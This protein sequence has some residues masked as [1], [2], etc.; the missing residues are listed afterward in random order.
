MWVCEDPCYCAELGWLVG[1]QWHLPPNPDQGGDTNPPL[2][3]MPKAPG[4]C[5]PAAVVWARLC[6]EEMPSPASTETSRA[7]LRS[8]ARRVED[9]GGE[10]QTSPMRP[11]VLFEDQSD[12]GQPTMTEPEEAE[13]ECAPGVEVHISAEGYADDTYMV[14]VSI[15]SLALMLAATSQWVRLTGQEINVKKSMVF[16][17]GQVMGRSAQ[18]LRAELDG[19]Q[20]PVQREFRQ[21]G[22][23]VRTAPKRGT[24]PL[25]E[26]RMESAKKALRKAR[27]L[28][29]GFEG[30]ALIVAVMILAA[31]LYGA[32]LADVTMKHAMGLEAAVLHILWGPTKP[33]RAKEIVFALLVPGHRMAPTMLIPY[34]RACWLANLARTRG[35]PQ[36]IAQAVWETNPCTLY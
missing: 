10:D 30:R 24:G 16:G 31:G 12:E 32:E 13:D 2:R 21:L 5:T 33:C 18:P 7:S 4:E 9:L 6:P 23:G 29:V 1:N 25:M 15:V 14:A 20:L 22:M 27:M 26:K 11:R 34:K 35:T 8:P 28:P 17:V 36:S 19:E 3:P